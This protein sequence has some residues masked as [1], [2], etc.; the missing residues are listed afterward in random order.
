MTLSKYKTFSHLRRPYYFQK[1]GNSFSSCVIFTCITSFLHLFSI[2]FFL[3]QNWVKKMQYM[4]T[5]EY[6]SVLKRK[7]ILTLAT[8][9]MTLEDNMLSEIRVTKGQMLCFFTHMR[10]Q[11]NGIHRDGRMVV[12]R[13]WGEEEMSRYYLISTEVQ[14]CRLKKVL[15]TD[16][17]DVCTIM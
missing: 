2:I 4:H 1:N 10:C 11:S 14:F 8:T 17:G 15:E 9:W 5:M 6:H 3:L 7:E 13:S 16:G 12:A